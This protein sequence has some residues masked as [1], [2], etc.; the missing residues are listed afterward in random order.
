MSSHLTGKG[1]KSSPVGQPEKDF[2]FFTLNIKITHQDRKGLSSRS[3]LQAP[4]R[5]HR[6]RPFPG[7]AGPG[8]EAT[9]PPGLQQGPRAPSPG[10]RGVS[11][12]ESQRAAPMGPLGESRPARPGP[13]PP[14]ARTLKD[15][16]LFLPRTKD[17]KRS[18]GATH[19]VRAP[20]SAPPGRPHPSPAP[21]RP[22]EPP[23]RTGSSR[24]GPGEPPRPLP[25]RRFPRRGPGRPG[26]LC[27][28]LRPRRAA[29]LAPAAAASLPRAC[30]PPGRKSPPAGGPRGRGGTPDSSRCCCLSGHLVPCVC[31]VSLPSPLSAL[32][33]PPPPPPALLPPRPTHH[34]TWP[35]CCGGSCCDGSSLR[36]VPARSPPPSSP[37][38][39]RSPRSQYACALPPARRGHWFCEFPSTL[40]R[41]RPHARSQASS[42][43]LTTTTSIL[44]A[45]SDPTPSAESPRIGW[46]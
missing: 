13:P 6:R 20:R 4:A 5:G 2:F 29:R 27:R 26:R 25:Q 18:R 36:R 15:I 1:L 21:G 11:R 19:Q 38:P 7:G 10:P 31:G 16:L 43:R 35:L 44:L 40:S 23:V 28:G 9:P 41:E 8:N 34:T 17:N 22:P 30:G 39:A 33:P 12:P 45:N 3:P 37:P 32:L 42:S 14:P 24:P 46:S